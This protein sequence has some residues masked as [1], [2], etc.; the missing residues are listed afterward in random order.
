MSELRHL[1]VLG[2]HRSGTSALAEGLLRLGVPG[3]SPE[4]MLAA[5]Q[6]N[7]NGYFEEREMVAC[8]EAILQAAGRAC[9][10]PA[11]KDL[12]LPELS[13]ELLARMK[14][15]LAAEPT[16]A[17]HKDPRLCQTLR[18]W[19]PLAGEASA[20]LIWRHPR[21]VAASMQRRNR[22]PAVIGRV[23]WEVYTRQA[24]QN[25]VALPR[26]VV[27]YDDLVREPRAVFERLRD[28]LAERKLLSERVDVDAAA[29]RIQGVSKNAADDVDD[30]DLS[31]SQRRLL[32]ALKKG[33]TPD[34]NNPVSAPD[35]QELLDVLKSVNVGEAERLQ[36]QLAALQEKCAHLDLEARSYRHL[37]NRPLV[38]AYRG[39]KRRL[40]ALLGGGT[41]A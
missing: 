34:L 13:E 20:I 14:A 32:E 31:E 38:R 35:P 28:F 17:L 37:M 9:Y 33:E 8:N 25:S 18:C 16:A 7:P 6:W 11:V 5:D 3:P 4:R 36:R 23:L 12:G 15:C 2:M 30:A 19:L 22:F 40:G 41:Q 27:A 21:Q 10:A 39:V 24:F 1:F 29:A 26:V